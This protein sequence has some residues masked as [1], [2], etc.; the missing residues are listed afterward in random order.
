MQKYEF[1]AETKQ[2]L[3]LVIHSIYTNKEIFLRELISNASDAI[4]KRR[5]ESLTNA[6]IS[7]DENN[8]EIF[9]TPDENTGTLTI[10][11][12]GIGMTR[13]E[14]LS[15]I[16]TIAKS[17]TKAF[18]EKLKE[19]NSTPDTNLIGQFGIGF[20]SAFMVADTV[21]ILTKSATGAEAFLW[22]SDGDGT[23]NI[24]VAEKEQIGTEITLKLKEEFKNK[25]EQAENF[26]DKFTIQRLVKKYSDYVRF[27]IKMFYP[28]TENN[29]EETKTLNSMAPLWTKNKS[30]ITEEEYNQ[31]YKHLFFDWQDPLAHMHSK[32]EGLLEFTSLLYIPSHA[33]F[34]FYQK[35]HTTGI[36]LYSKNIFIMDDCKELLPMHLRFVRGVVDS[37]DLALNVSR[38]I[39]QQNSAL[40]KIGK[41]IEKAVLKQLET[42][43]KNDREKYISFWK[44]FG[45]AIKHGV[46]A[47]HDGRDKLKPLLLVNSSKS[48]ELTTLAEYVSRM[49]EGQKVIYYVVGKDKEAIEALPQMEALSEKGLEV[50]YLYDKIDE[51]AVDALVSFEEKK[52]QSI[53]RGNLE[54]DDVL[55]EETKKEQENLNTEFKDLLEEVKEVLKEKITD[56]KISS[57]L[58]SSPVCLVTSNDGIS[59]SMEQV[60]AEMDHVGFKAQRVLELNTKH[61]VFTKLEIEFSMNKNSDRFKDYCELLYGQALLLEGLAPENPAKF[62]KI[63]ASLM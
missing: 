2:L 58:K 55:S 63:V 20:Y 49:K 40:K 35:E 51:F 5:F 15:N 61:N 41:N 9:I 10:S 3:D 30:E 8:F 21:S 27:P 18:I 34:D 42:L 36:R 11:D 48:D 13:E 22:E 29:E 45:R 47:D 19:S 24:K 60:L 38:E 32:V 25:N 14:L 39:L 7:N 54:L 33:P 59:L 56:V 37:P 12:N 44:E 53:S 16:G 6:E 52:F 23:F 31:L 4:D 28:K 46:Y 50:I 62:A 43:L 17:G 1:Q 57:R 26:L